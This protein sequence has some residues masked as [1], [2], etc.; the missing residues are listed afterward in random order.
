MTTLSLTPKQSVFLIEQMSG[1][2]CIVDEVVDGN[3]NTVDDN[4]ITGFGP[5]ECVRFT[6]SLDAYLWEC[7]NSFAAISMQN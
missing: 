3:L 6:L 5:C 7:C 4:E 1:D 2:T